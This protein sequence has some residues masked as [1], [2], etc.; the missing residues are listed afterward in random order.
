MEKKMENNETM[1]SKNVMKNV[2]NNFVQWLNNI[3]WGKFVLFVLFVCIGKNIMVNM[4]N[5]EDDTFIDNI[6][7]LFIFISFG[8][9][10]FQKP[11]INL[12]KNI[13]RNINNQVS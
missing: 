10:F 4:L 6:T 1:L 8:I 9:K 11:R 5:I 7:T 12:D 2:G 3:S 13:D